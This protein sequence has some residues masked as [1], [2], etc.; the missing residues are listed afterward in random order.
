[1]VAHTKPTLKWTNSALQINIYRMKREKE[2]KKTQREKKDRRTERRRRKKKLARTSIKPIKNLG[3]N[4]ILHTFIY[5]YISFV[6]RTGICVNM[7]CLSILDCCPPHLY[8]FIRIFI[9]YTVFLISSCSF[10]LTIFE[11]VVL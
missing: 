5:T 8:T 2:I 6:W 11:T 10:F 3:S 9:N 7:F 4:G 1:M